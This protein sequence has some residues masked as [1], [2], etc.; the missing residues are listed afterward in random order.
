MAPASITFRS[1]VRLDVDDGSIATVCLNRPD[2]HNGVDFTMI[3]ALLDAARHVRRTPEIRAVMLKGEGPSFCAGLDVKGV[4]RDRR[5]LLRVFFEMF[6][7]VANIF[8]RVNLVWR[9]LP[10]PVVAVM[11]GNCF[12]AGLQLAAGAD[13]RF[14]TPDA[15][16]SIMEAK[17]GL[18]PD[19]GAMVTLRRLLNRDHLLDLM[20]TARVLEA[21]EAQSIGLVTRVSDTPEVEARAWL[22]EVLTRSPDAI[23]AARKLLNAAEAARDHGA[24]AAERRWQRRVMG[25]FNQRQAV[26]QHLAGE[27]GR[28]TPSRFR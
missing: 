12:G 17:W 4:M 26:R 14:A 6:S 1:R 13:L 7:P 24:L 22:A 8:Q 23:D 9:E 2:K 5:R 25:R 21:A 18:V 20:L 19:M 3:Q 16:L 27:E 11:H 10:V 28:Y 15:R